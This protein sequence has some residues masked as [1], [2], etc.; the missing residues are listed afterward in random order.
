MQMRSYFN[1]GI[2]RP[3]SFRKEQLKKLQ[4]AVKKYE[5]QLHEGLFTDLK[6][7][8]EECWVTETGFLLAE[9]SNSLKH[10]KNWMEDESV[11]TNLLNLPSKRFV[12][13]EPLGVMLIISPW[14]YH[15]QLLVKPLAGA[16]ADG[17]CVVI[18]V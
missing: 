15:F 18:K 13:K 16:M 2:T 4:A 1:S 10:L 14:N 5:A 6:K 8:P 12:L 7:S 3:C 17:N 11:S 9:I